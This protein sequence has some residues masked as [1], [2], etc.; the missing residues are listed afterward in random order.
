[1]KEDDMKRASGAYGGGESYIQGFGGEHGVKS[2]FGRPEYR[3][4]NDI[5]NK[6]LTGR[7]GLDSIKLSQ[8]GKIWRCS[9]NTVMTLRVS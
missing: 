6:S 1:M 4:E 2:S 7:R 8:N 5:K 3:W 9:V